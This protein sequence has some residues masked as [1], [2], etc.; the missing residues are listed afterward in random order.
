LSGLYQNI[1]EI[2][3]E[4]IK[5]L[6]DNFAE[7]YTKEELNTRLEVQLKKALGS[8]GIGGVRGFSFDGTKGINKFK[9]NSERQQKVANF[10]NTLI[11]ALSLYSKDL[12]QKTSWAVVDEFTT[13]VA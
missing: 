4:N 8:H 2:E 11:L 13:K 10:L 3:R 7:F 6:A 5:S 12:A 1:F 9:S